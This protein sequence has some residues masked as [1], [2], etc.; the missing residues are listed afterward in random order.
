MPQYV[1]GAYRRRQVGP[2]RRRRA[3]CSGGRSSFKGETR[4]VAASKKHNECKQCTQTNSH[5]TIS[6]VHL[7]S[8][9]HSHAPIISAV[10]AFGRCRPLHVRV[11]DFQ[12][13]QLSA[14]ALTSFRLR[15]FASPVKRHQRL[16]CY[17]LMPLSSCHCPRR[18]LLCS[19]S[20]ACLCRI[21][22]RCHPRSQ[23]WFHSLSTKRE[24]SASPHV[25]R[26]TTRPYMVT[27]LTSMPH[28]K[29]REILP[30]L[31][32]WLQGNK[33]AKIAFNGSIFSTR[34]SL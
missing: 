1:P 23:P 32:L 20:E 4:A 9:R 16:S 2:V 13:R 15:L 22:C 12:I 8:T 29:R 26:P 7:R 5:D 28:F 6:I 10:N 19:M 25:E 11:P 31:A 17:Q 27:K 18:S 21:P 30:C 3:I 33:A 24:S 14:L 34:V